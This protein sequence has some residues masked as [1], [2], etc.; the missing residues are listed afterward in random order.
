MIKIEIDEKVLDRG[1]HVEVR[2]R[3]DVIV[4][5]EVPKA[6]QIDYFGENKSVK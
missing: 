2:K 4:I 6:K 3:K 5:L 1:S